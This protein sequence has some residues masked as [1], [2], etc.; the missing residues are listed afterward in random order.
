MSNSQDHDVDDELSRRFKAVF[1]KEPVS[2]D[3]QGLSPWS[4]SGNDYEVDD[5]E[6]CL[7]SGKLLMGF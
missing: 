3:R 7:L 1:N 5:E 4:T 2:Q 6:V